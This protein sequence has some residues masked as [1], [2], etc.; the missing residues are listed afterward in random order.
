MSVKR[1]GIVVAILIVVGAVGYFGYRFVS[2][3]MTWRH[4]DQTYQEQFK[5]PAEIAPE[6]KGKTI[7]FHMKTGLDQD[8]SQ[9]CVGFNVILAS[10]EAGAKVTVVLDA[11][12]LLDLTGTGHN[13][14]STGVPLRLKKLI[15]AQMNLPLKQMPNNYKEYLELLN[16]RG[17]SVFANTAMLIV[18]GDA[19]Q[20]Q[21]KVAGYDFIEPVTYARL[22]ELLMQAD[23]VI[24]Y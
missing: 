6:L 5:P 7:V 19:E 3:L 1:D 20:A 17:A 2:K 15:A 10:L 21:A 16:Q 14:E 11:G 9:I 23:L 4:L 24:V 12:A 8:D 13:L 18:T 22:A